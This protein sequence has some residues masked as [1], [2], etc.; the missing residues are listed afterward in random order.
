M[1]NFRGL[2]DVKVEVLSR[3]LDAEKNGRGVSHIGERDIYI[4]IYAYIH[5]YT[6]TGNTC[7]Y[8]YIYTYILFVY[9]YDWL[10]CIM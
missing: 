9:I 4:Q 7:A 2:L 3:K 10:L 1:L 5:I 8:I 6:H